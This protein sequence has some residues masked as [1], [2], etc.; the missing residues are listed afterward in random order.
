MRHDDFTGEGKAQLEQS[1][2][3]AILAQGPQG[4]STCHAYLRRFSLLL[5]SHGAMEDM[6]VMMLLLMLVA[7]SA[8]SVVR[9]WRPSCLQPVCSTTC[10]TAPWRVPSVPSRAR[11][12]ALVALASLRDPGGWAPCARA[13]HRWWT[14]SWTSSACSWRGGLQ[15]RELLC[16]QLRGGWASVSRSSCRSS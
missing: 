15:A 4:S 12:A 2:S 3:V 14:S 5:L 16:G 8:E 13:A 1:H 10:S 6:M 11:W 9:L 7:L